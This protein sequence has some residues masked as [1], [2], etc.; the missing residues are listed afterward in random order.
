MSHGRAGRA[1]VL[2]LLA[3]SAA[4][5]DNPKPAPASSSTPQR[6]LSAAPAAS[7]PARPSV[8]ASPPAPV[9][10]VPL[11]DAGPAACALAYGPVQRAFRGYGALAATGDGVDVIF[12]QA[13]VPSV[14]HLARGVAAGE[15]RETATITK[16]SFPPCVAAG[17]FLYCLDGGGVIQ[18]TP[19]SGGPPSAIGKADKGA[20][21]AATTL[22][23]AH[24]AVG[25]VASGADGI[26]AAYVAVD[27]GAPLRVSADASGASAINLAPVGDGALALIIDGRTATTQAHARKLTFTGQASVSPDVVLFLGEPPLPYT[28]GVIGAGDGR[29]FMLLP[30]QRGAS[31]F[32]L[33]T[34]RIDD[35]PRS[36]AAPSWSLYPNGLNPSG[37]AATQGSGPLYVARVRPLARDPKSP[38]VLELGRISAA[39]A[40]EAMGIVPTHGTTSDV[41]MSADAS[42]ALWILYTDTEGSWLERR[43]CASK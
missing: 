15:T 13:G 2:T 6:T 40:F 29:F 23:S 5:K 34:L 26:G 9:A 42:G 36:D 35:P 4:C 43:A 38:R 11:L 22:G 28:R 27:D 12:H 8:A 16:G 14:T 18:R 25:F 30:L 24:A 33:V 21:L 17:A 19:R 3:L 37:V 41:A 10:N 20:R 32:G 7:T 39:G 31:D 1:A